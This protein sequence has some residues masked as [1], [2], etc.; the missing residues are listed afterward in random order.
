M[1][2]LR[3]TIKVLIRTIVYL[4]VFGMIFSVAI[5][6]SLYADESISRLSSKDL[7]LLHNLTFVARITI[8]F[9]IILA[10]SKIQEISNFILKNM[11]LGF[12]KNK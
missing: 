4:L 6:C 1:E 3:N 10:I 11:H 12:K 2:L 8:I 9:S 5:N 7:L